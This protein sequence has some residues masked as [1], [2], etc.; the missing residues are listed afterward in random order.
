MITEAMQI[1]LPLPNGVPIKV[2]TGMGANWLE[3]H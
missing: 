2:D 1:A 3:A